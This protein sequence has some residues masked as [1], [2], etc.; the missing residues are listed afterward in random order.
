M[1]TTRL[2]PVL[3]ACLAAAAQ[4][5]HNFSR[6][7]TVD[8]SGNAGYTTIQDAIDAI[9]PANPAIQQTILIF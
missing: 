4:G 3:A 5:Q 2:V 7:L 8:P 6:T 9:V 1:T